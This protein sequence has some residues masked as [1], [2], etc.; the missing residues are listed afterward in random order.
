MR[1]RA[2]KELTTE[3]PLLLIGS[4][5]CTAF[6]AWQYI[7]NSKRDPEVVAKE[8]ARGLRHLTFCYEMYEYQVSQGRNFLH[9]HPAQATS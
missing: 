8:Y 3:K 1:D 9:E 7:N 5:M 4:P 2:W 6:S